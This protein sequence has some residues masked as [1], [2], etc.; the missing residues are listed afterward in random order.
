MLLFTIK[1]W[2]IVCS[3]CSL[4]YI[5]SKL[6]LG[7]NTE[8]RLL[9]FPPPPQ[10]VHNIY[11]GIYRR[12]HKKHNIQTVT[13]WNL[14]EVVDDDIKQKQIAISSKIRVNLVCNVIVCLDK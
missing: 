10:I 13:W 11:M 5:Y 7:V 3:C 1:H 2:K 9:Y 14:T 6:V 12:N 4:Y 8:Y